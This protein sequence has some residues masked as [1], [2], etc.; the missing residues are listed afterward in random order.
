MKKQALILALFVLTTAFAQAQ[1]ALRPYV[2]I[3]SHTLTKDFT[4][5]NWKSGLGYQAGVD[6]Q[7][8]SQFFVQPGLQI[9][10]AKNQLDSANISSIFHLK[11]THFRLP[12][13]VG[14]AFGNLDGNF[15]FRIFTGPNASIVVSEN[16]G[17]FISKSDLKN[18]VF[19]WN[20][21]AGIDISIIFVDLGY[22]VGLSDVFKSSVDN[23]SKDNFFYAN[24]GIRLHF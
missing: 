14:Y 22:Q 24:A 15:S 1:I 6:F 4:D 16:S 5:A 23:G 2:G 20:A 11:R 17:G 13:M 19:G 7:I 18:T 21:G 8:G 3:N 9:E 10:F 12:V